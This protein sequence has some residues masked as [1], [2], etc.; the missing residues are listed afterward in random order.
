MILFNTLSK[1]KEDLAALTGKKPGDTVKLYTCGPTVYNHATIGNMRTYVSNDL[2]ER[3]LTHLGYQVDRVMNITDVGHLTGDNLGDA[4]LG[5]DRLDKAV[6][7]ENRDVEE[8]IQSYTD[9]FLRDCDK[10]NI[11]IPKK[12]PR[13]SKYVTEEKELIQKLF[14]RG[15]AYDT[16]EAV[17]FDTPKFEN[18]GALSGQKLEEKTIASREE[19]VTGEHKRHPTDFALWFKLTGRFEHHLMHWPSPWGEGFPG[20]HLE[21][22]AMIHSLLGEPIDI[23]TGGVDH[24][25]T[26]HTNE[27][28]QSE[29]AFGVPL[30]KIW[31]HFEHL[32]VDGG[33]MGKSVGNAYTMT[34]LE[35]KGINPLAF[36]YLCLQ[37]HWR[38]KMN[39]TWEALAGAVAA[40]KNLNGTIYRIWPKKSDGIE[41]VFSVVLGQEAETHRKD[42]QSALSDD[43]NFP[44][45]LAV[46]HETLGD[47]RI[48]NREKAK[49]VGEFDQVLGITISE[50]QAPIPPKI[51]DLMNA[52]EESR[53][54]KQF[55]Q[56][57]ELR[58]KIRALGYE[59]EDKPDGPIAYPSL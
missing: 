50:T 48:A 25:G 41:D 59:V 13:A 7:R 6:A 3:A 23:H 57:D 35:A 10:L 37:T 40:Q 16:P 54:N 1:K 5:E 31:V 18:Y 53:R 27:I 34:D 46:L 33:R 44:Q 17:Y 28:A 52:R 29:G 43:L 39:F 22:S 8:I 32:L 12:L 38:N 42:F 4:D 56:A 21:C 14:E 47:E 45:A 36:R 2:L 20:W 15:F 55:M 11:R 19:V 9:S 58:D 24:I 30:T 26:H 49:L 51:L